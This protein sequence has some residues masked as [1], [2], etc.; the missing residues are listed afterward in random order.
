MKNIAFLAAHKFCVHFADGIDAY[1]QNTIC[2]FC[3][4][5]EAKQSKGIASIFMVSN[6]TY[7]ANIF[8]VI[9]NKKINKLFRV[10]LF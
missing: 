9:L 7:F 10:F 2:G 8:D 6:Y 1:L 3:I 5:V 4:K